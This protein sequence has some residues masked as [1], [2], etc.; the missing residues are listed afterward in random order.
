VF[1]AQGVR[2]T[3]R[4]A[5]SDQTPARARKAVRNAALGCRS[6]AETA[7]LAELLTSELVTNALRHAPGITECVVRFAAVAGML[8]VEVF[9]QGGGIPTPRSQMDDDAE[10]GRGLGIVAALATDWGVRFGHG[11]KCVFFTLAAPPKQ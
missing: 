5:V 1:E 10:S 2:W 8:T 6:V 9:D 4:F 3:Y 7:D 11:G